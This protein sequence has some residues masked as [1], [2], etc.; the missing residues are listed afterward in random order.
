MLIEAARGET[1]MFTLS[2]GTG[3]GL[4]NQLCSFYTRGTL[5]TYVLYY[6]VETIKCTVVLP[7]GIM[8]LTALFM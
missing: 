7:S 1:L 4:Q 8:H 6:T 5:A 3:T 2:H